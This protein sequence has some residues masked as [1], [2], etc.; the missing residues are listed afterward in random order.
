MSEKDASQSEGAGPSVSGSGVAPGESER[1][2]SVKMS[3][4]APARVV[5]PGGHRIVAV[6]CGLHH[7]VLLSEH[8]WFT[9]TL[10][11]LYVLCVMGG[12]YRIVFDSILKKSFDFFFK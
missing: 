2:A 11:L 8:G 3:C 12:L 10:M 1:D 7:T 9:F 5:I 4:L 6:A